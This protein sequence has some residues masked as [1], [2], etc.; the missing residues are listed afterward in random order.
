MNQTRYARERRKMDT[1]FKIDLGS[2]VKHRINDI[3]GT[4]TGRIQYLTGCNQYCVIRPGLNKDEKPHEGLWFDEDMIVV[5]GK[6][7]PFPRKNDGGPGES[8]PPTSQH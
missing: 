4:V 1:N 5:T 7:K 2:K 6:I 8:S 3:S